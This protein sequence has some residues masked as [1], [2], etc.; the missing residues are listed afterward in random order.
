[1]VVDLYQGVDGGSG[2]GYYLIV[3]GFLLMLLFFV[4]SCPVFFT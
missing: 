4:L 1:M 2:D 3:V